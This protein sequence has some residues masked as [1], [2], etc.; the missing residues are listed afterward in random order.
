MFNDIKKMYI[1]SYILSVLLL[2]PIWFLISFFIKLAMGY[3]EAIQH[4]TWEVNKISAWYIYG[5]SF[6]GIFTIST[7]LLFTFP[8]LFTLIRIYKLEERHNYVW[9]FSFIASFFPF[10]SIF[11]FTQILRY[12]Q[13]KATK[14]KINANKRTW[15][16]LKIV[17]IIISSVFITIY[18]LITFLNISRNKPWTSNNYEAPIFS[19]N[20]STPNT[21]EIFTDGFDQDYF[22]GVANTDKL[23]NFQI[24]PNVVTSSFHTEGS[25]KFLMNGDKEFANL[26]GKMVAKDPKYAGIL[27]DNERGKKYL[28]NG[29]SNLEFNNWRTETLRNPDQMNRIGVPSRWLSGKKYHTLDWMRA[30]KELKTKYGLGGFSEFS[31]AYELFIRDIKLG[32]KKQS[33]NYL[34]DEL[35]HI[36]PIVMA[37]GKPNIF[38]VKISEANRYLYNFLLRLI[39]KLESIKIGTKNLTLYD[40]TNIYIYGD[41]ASHI[42][43]DASPFTK[44]NSNKNRT[45]LIVKPAVK[46]EKQ[47][48][49]SKIHKD[50]A[51]WAPFIRRIINHQELF[52]ND[53]IVS[54]I[55]TNP[56]FDINRKYIT[57]SKA[58]SKGWWMNTLDINTGYTSGVNRYKNGWVRELSKFDVSDLKE[59]L[60][61]N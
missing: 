52:P 24:Y 7:Y 44:Q 26:Y 45:M 41:H 60:W 5:K 53:S 29:M 50:R 19:E 47:R 59:V 22:L 1:L 13:L 6:Q 21:I 8:F 32:Q 25:Y 30:K 40:N 56:N 57:Y 4:G 33:Y 2:I 14:S 28:L 23:K 27:N 39:K 31:F 42:K 37:N 12:R 55:D 20:L 17:I 49:S 48:V 51:I 15:V 54:W 18:P 36:P 3:Q 58:M 11:W 43:L 34:E 35:T 61:K 46:N 9:L 16:F 10:G 38:G